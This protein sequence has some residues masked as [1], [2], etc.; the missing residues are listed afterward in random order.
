M[1]K[2]KQKKQKRPKQKKQKK[3]MKLHGGGIF[4]K[5]KHWFFKTA[6]KATPMGI[7]QKGTNPRVFNKKTGKWERVNIIPRSFWKEAGV[8][9]KEL[10][11]WRYF[12]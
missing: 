5:I 8:P 4:D 7:L 6:I 11:K 1:P 10:D 2:R 3:R 9:D 12:K